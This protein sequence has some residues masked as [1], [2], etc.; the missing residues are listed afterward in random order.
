MNTPNLEEIDMDIQVEKLRQALDLVSAAIPRG[1]PG[2][3]GLPIS[4]SVLFRNGK[5]TA[6]NLEI[7]ISVELPELGRSIP[8]WSIL[9]MNPGRSDV[10]ME[11]A[12]LTSQ[13]GQASPAKGLPAHASALR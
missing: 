9:T 5:L 6:T 4:S 12:Q 2:K 1:S 7:W 8:G 10:V 11:A 3:S 13:P